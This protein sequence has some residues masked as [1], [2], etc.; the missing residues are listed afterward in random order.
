MKAK[1]ERSPK[2]GNLNLKGRKEL[3]LDFDFRFGGIEAT[4]CNGRATS[5]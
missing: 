5:G 2:G 3:A 4:E 1:R